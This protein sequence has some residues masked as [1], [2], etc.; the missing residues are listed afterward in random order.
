M[1]SSFI[2]GNE[3]FRNKYRD[4][5][6]TKRHNNNNNNN[7]NNNDTMPWYHKQCCFLHVIAPL[8]ICHFKNNKNINLSLLNN[9]GC[10][11][12]GCYKFDNLN[13]SN[14][15]KI[16]H[17][18]L[19]D[20]SLYFGTKNSLMS[21]I[22]FKIYSKQSGK[23]LNKCYRLLKRMAGGMKRSTQPKTQKHIIATPS[24][25]NTRLIFKLINNNKYKLYFSIGIQKKY[26]LQFNQL[27]NNNNNNNNNNNDDIAYWWYQNWSTHGVI[28]HI[29][30]NLQKH[31]LQPLI[32]LHHNKYIGDM[33]ENLK[34]LDLIIYSNQKY[35]NDN[36]DKFKISINGKDILKYKQIEI[37]NNNKIRKI[38]KTKKKIIKVKRNNN[39]NNQ[40][41][42]SM[43]KYRNSMDKFLKLSKLL[44]N[45]RKLL[46]INNNNNNNFSSHNLYLNIGICIISPKER[47]KII[48]NNDSN[49]NNLLQE[50]ASIKSY[51]NNYLIYRLQ[52]IQKNIKNFNFDLDILNKEIYSF[53]E[54]RNIKQM[55]LLS[56]KNKYNHCYN[57][58]FKDILNK[59]ENLYLSTSKSSTS[60]LSIILK[61]EKILKTNKNKNYIKIARTFGVKQLLIS[62]L[63]IF[64]PKNEKFSIIIFGKYQYLLK[65]ITIYV[66]NNI[67][68]NYDFKLNPNIFIHEK[69]RIFKYKQ[70]DILQIREIKEHSKISLLSNQYGVY[71]KIYLPKN[72]IIGTFIGCEYFENEYNNNYINNIISFNLFPLKKSYKNGN[73][74]INIDYNNKIIL[75]C[76]NNKFKYFQF[77]S[78][79]NDSRSNFI[80]NNNFMTQKDVENHN[81]DLI[82]IYLNGWP[83]LFLITNCNINK[84]TELM[85][86][87][88]QKQIEYKLYNNGI[89]WR[90]IKQN[91]IDHLSF[92]I[93]NLYHNKYCNKD[94]NHNNNDIYNEK[95]L[96]L[97]EKLNRIHSEYLLKVTN[98]ANQL[99]LLSQHQQQQQQQQQQKNN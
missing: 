44:N 9:C 12:I 48:K 40:Y 34:K 92:I 87:Y 84:D 45:R 20:L 50:R 14:L 67:K 28:E 80:N 56:I 64:K 18:S 97:K 33:Y 86:N 15:Y 1:S 69:L 16:S 73:K 58:W 59:M 83:F 43:D 29:D 5:L 93:N 23:E 3:Q 46:I 17:I 2:L 36:N 72:T 13:I 54:K 78:Y 62:K 90:G 96:L 39:N 37:N 27:F 61:K 63:K 81:I 21:N 89:I 82:I 77:A 99:N 60:K 76:N 71:N 8:I 70:S 57:N 95:L 4:I 26:L 6:P 32:I 10:Q 22:L 98:L 7:N 30:N 53:D 31:I 74:N 79:L 24:F 41:R 11:S 47:N 65:E 91:Q 94:N 75:N 66:S 55:D 52:E 51:K 68:K 49:Y 38:I 85:I 88:S 19:Y 42:Y 35:N 25:N